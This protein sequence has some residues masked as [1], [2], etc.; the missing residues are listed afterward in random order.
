MHLSRAIAPIVPIVLLLGVAGASAQDKGKTGITMGYP[1]S[2]GFVMHV[3]ERVAIRPEL[4]FSTG[5]TETEGLFASTSDGFTIA[6]GFSA[7]IYIG[8]GDKLRPYVSPSY[9]FA[10]TSA[11]SDSAIAGETESSSSSHTGAGAFGAQYSL[12]DRFTVFGEV[13]VGTSFSSQK[14]GISG[15]RSETRVVSTRTRVGVVFYF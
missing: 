5:T 1:T 4:N 3:N 15:G 13:G 9:T 11:S 6:V 12:H 10:H 2:V 7:L 14:I 8:E